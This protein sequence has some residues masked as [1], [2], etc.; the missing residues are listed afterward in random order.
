M[1]DTYCEKC[2]SPMLRRGNEWKCP[3][4]DDIQMYSEDDDG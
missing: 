2:G 3:V 1:S 4:C